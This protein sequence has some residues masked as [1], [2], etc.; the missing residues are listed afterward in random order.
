MDR[1]HWYILFGCILGLLLFI[2]WMVGIL[3]T[4]VSIAM[5]TRIA[6]SSK[7]ICEPKFFL[8]LSISCFYGSTMAIPCFL[9]SVEKITNCI[10]DR[11]GCLRNKIKATFYVWSN[12]EIAECTNKVHKK[13]KDAISVVQ[14]IL[15]LRNEGL[16]EESENVSV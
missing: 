4:V 13:L 7:S 2:T 8:F 10:L 14:I 16:L 1:D 15:R 9:S 11:G 5:I 12:N 3:Y 6:D